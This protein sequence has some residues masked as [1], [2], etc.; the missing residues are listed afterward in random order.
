MTQPTF[1]EPV[2]DR[3][4]SPRFSAPK[5][6]TPKRDRTSRQSADADFFA[7]YFRSRPNTWISALELM[8][9][10]ACLSFRTRISDLR[11][12]PY[13]MQI[14]NKQATVSGTRRSFYKFIPVSGEGQ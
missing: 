2:P 12:A 3:A 10:R 9:L 11:Y 5:P 8:N 14:V 6:D 7:A 1:F 13:E 4:E